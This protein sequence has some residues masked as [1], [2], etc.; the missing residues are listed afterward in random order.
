MRITPP[1]SQCE[2]GRSE[3]CGCYQMSL[4]KGYRL[5]PRCFTRGGRCGIYAA[6]K[7]GCARRFVWA[8]AAAVV[9]LLACASVRVSAQQAPATQPTLVTEQLFR[10]I[11]VLKGIPIDTFFDVMGM[12]ASSMGED[13][14]FCHSKE[15]VFRHEAFGDETP[16]IRRAR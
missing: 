9:G 16:R 12:F 8:A 14:T 11:Q 13:C 6:M 7:A 15:A 4:Q 5:Q 1:I 10:N 2:L 3:S